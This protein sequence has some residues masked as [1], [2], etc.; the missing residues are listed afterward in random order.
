MD[1]LCDAMSSTEI[2]IVWSLT[3][4]ISI[5]STYLLTKRCRKSMYDRLA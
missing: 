2:T 1:N 5:L 3:L 4:V